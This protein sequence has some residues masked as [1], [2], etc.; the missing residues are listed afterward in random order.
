[1]S[2]RIRGYMGG[3]NVSTRHRLALMLLALLL[4]ACASISETQRLQAQ[5]AYERGMSHLN[6]KQP[7]PALSALQEAVAL[8]PSVALYRDTLG[9]L[10]LDLGRPDLAIEQLRRAVEIDPKLADAH[11]HLGTAYA[12]AARW[13]EAVASY[14]KA[15]ALPTVSVPD[16]VHQN[17]GLALYHLK[18]YAEAER[19]LRFAISLDPQLQAA[20]YNLG[21]VF[22]AENRPE[23]AK[24]A[25]RR[26]RLLGPDSPFGQA[27]LERLRALG[28]GG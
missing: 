15:L 8:D 9:V 18:R 7:S 27:A 26:A 2:A 20:Y 13:D 14:R 16:F 12:E 24:A 6:D 22:V 11:F 25:F 21:L 3:E 23:D 5:A 10:L 4:P 17:L 19:A 28:D 1:M